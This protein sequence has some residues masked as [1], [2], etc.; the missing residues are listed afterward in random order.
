MHVHRPS[1]WLWLLWP[2]ALA[3]GCSVESDLSTKPCPCGPGFICDPVRDRCIA[4][5][6][7][8]GECTVCTERGCEAAPDGFGC[9]D[10]R[11]YAGS[12]CRGCYDGESCVV[13]DALDACGMA[14]VACDD[15]R[16]EGDVCSAGSCAPERQAVDLTSGDQH[17]CVALD[18]SSLW[19][20]GAFDDGQLGRASEDALPRAVAAAVPNFKGAAA[21]ARH[22][23]G[24]GFDKQITCWG[25]NSRA[26]VG[27]PLDL[28]S[29]MTPVPLDGPPRWLVVAAGATHNCA[30]DDAFELY[31]WG[32]NGPSGRLGRDCVDRST[33]ELQQVDGEDWR[34]VDSQ[35]N[36]SC[37]LAGDSSLWCWGSNIDG[38]LGTGDF[39]DRCTPVRVAGD[40]RA[41][42]VGGFHSCAIREDDTVQCWGGNQHGQLGRGFV[43][44][45]DMNAVPATVEGSFKSV[46]SGASHS[47]GIDEGDALRCW[48][49]NDHSQ[50]GVD[51]ATD[52]P[53]PTVV[54]EG[55]TWR[56]V[57]LGVAHSCGIRSSGAVYCWGAA[58]LGQTGRGPEG[59]SA[60]PTRVCLDP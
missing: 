11:C 34:L 9:G 31:C 25:D 55:T 1:L 47:C 48:G 28:P 52:S 26:Q 16:C 5:C 41:L 43:G 20:W 56:K 13:G 30:I 42:G 10:G 14:G 12:C 40:W 15:C 50:L 8:G 19:C 44:A 37:A 32:N 59:D 54:F 4:D 33:P 53:S 46:A 6:G 51:G 17:A 22:T 3:L 49:H 39:K 23:C 36:H 27:Q 38:A 29:A 2:A 35:R 45:G 7:G 18:D 57:A 24:L 60:T 58:D 21:G